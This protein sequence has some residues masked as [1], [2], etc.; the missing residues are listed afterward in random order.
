VP[1]TITAH[2]VVRDP[3]NAAQWY[4]KVFRAVERSRIPLPGGKV[5]AIELAIGDSTLMI[6]E[7]FPD[8]GIVSPKTLGGT[9]GALVIATDDVDAMWRRAL[10]A[11][12]EVFHPLADTFWGE[13]FGQV[14]DPYGHRW[15]V[16]QHIRDVP[17]SEVV[18]AAAESF[19]DGPTR[20]RTT[21]DG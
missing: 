12:A 8:T 4:T 5:M 7:E 11:G 15:G 21:A 18:K 9:H 3:D 19:G 6:A 14:I 10:D 16:T 20:G 17:H 2:I 1:H 13:R